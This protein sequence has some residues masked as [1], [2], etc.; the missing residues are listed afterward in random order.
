[1]AVMAGR[2]PGVQAPA[3]CKLCWTANEWQEVH[4]TESTATALEIEFVNMLIAQEQR[5]PI[6]FTFYWLETG[7]WEGRDFQG[8]VASAAG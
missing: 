1:M 8:S 7:R 3:A 2:T 4:D 5:A 6:R